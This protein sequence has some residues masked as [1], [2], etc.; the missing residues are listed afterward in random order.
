MS[1]TYN[2]TGLKFKIHQ[3]VHKLDDWEGKI[4]EDRELVFDADT[5]K[6]K[7]GDGK[8]AWEKLDY[9]I[10]QDLSALLEGGGLHV[11]LEPSE[12]DSAVS[13]YYSDWQ[14]RLIRDELEIVKSNL[15]EYIPVKYTNTPENNIEANVERY[16]V[17]NSIAGTS[18]PIN[19]NNELDPET[20]WCNA[21][22]NADSDDNSVTVSYDI[23]LEGI[24]FT[25]PSNSTVNIWFRTDCAGHSGQDNIKFND[26][27]F[28]GTKTNPVEVTVPLKYL[29]Q[30]SI[31]SGFEYYLEI[32]HVD[33][34]GNSLEDV[35]CRVSTMN[36]S[37]N[38]SETALLEFSCSPKLSTGINNLLFEKDG[39]VR[40]ALKNS[41]ETEK[42][43]KLG[44]K[45]GLAKVYS[46]NKLTPIDTYSTNDIA[47][48]SVR[49]IQTLAGKEVCS[50]LSIPKAITDLPNYGRSFTTLD[51]ENLTFTDKSELVIL[52]GEEDWKL[53]KSESSGNAYVCSGFPKCVKSFKAYKETKIVHNLYKYDVYLENVGEECRIRFRTTG[54]FTNVDSW[55]DYLS[56]RHAVNRPVFV[57]YE[58]AEPRSV[59][60]LRPLLTTDDYN[61]IDTYNEESKTKAS[62]IAVEIDGYEDIDSKKSTFSYAVT[63][64]KRR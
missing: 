60:D 38:N 49:S 3:R 61:V 45:V 54:T 33:S 34:E 21:V 17:L 63:Y 18:K 11:P 2:K 15:L 6:I 57:L 55:K 9:F 19:R 14:D 39:I 47:N 27:D 44:V 56:G 43:V 50:S 51:F 25:L 12:D 28:A 16:A 23:T 58:R 20:L 13:K 10:D 26:E 22:P 41:S 1:N 52:T 8:T 29:A 35:N 37:D 31:P 30:G 40:I 42:S 7:L 64:V 53:L 24:D 48:A 36:T 5:G 62:K 4:L 32:C 59:T 46:D